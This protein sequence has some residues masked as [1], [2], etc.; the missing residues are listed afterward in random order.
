[1]KVPDGPSF[2]IILL[3]AG[4]LMGLPEQGQAFIDKPAAFIED[5][6]A[7]STGLR[8]ME[9]LFTG[10]TIKLSDDETLKLSYLR[11]CI[12]EEFKGGVVTVGETQSVTIGGRLQ[13]REKVD[14]DSGNIVPTRDQREDIAGS[15]FREPEAASGVRLVEIYATAPVFVFAEPVKELVIRREDSGVREEYRF[16]VDDHM[17]DLA[18]E[19]V[20]LAAGGIYRAE[21]E[22]DAIIFHIAREA[23]ATSSAAISRLIGF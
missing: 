23:T 20:P 2:S 16:A 10:D 6:K 13:Y 4:I 17:L 8:L 19:N 5:L 1:M 3:T 11:S 9:F 18:G 7:P 15:V 22:K 12:V 14:C 21:T